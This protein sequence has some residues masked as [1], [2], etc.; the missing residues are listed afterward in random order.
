VRYLLIGLLFVVPLGCVRTLQADRGG[1]A[2]GDA[3]L[4][5][6]DALFESRVSTD[7]AST[8]GEVG[9]SGEDGTSTTVQL[10]P[11][12]GKSGLVRVLGGGTRAQ[13]KRVAVDSKGR[14]VAVGHGGNV[15]VDYIVVRLSPDGSFDTS[16]NNGNP[17]LGSGSGTSFN[18][19]A[20]GLTTS[21]QIYVAG[22]IDGRYAL[23]RL[24]VDGSLDTTFAQNG[25][26]TFDRGRDTQSLRDLAVGSDGSLTLLGNSESP[27]G[28][29]SDSAYFRV[30]EQ[31]VLTL[32]GVSNPGP[33]FD[34]TSIASLY[35]A[36]A[37]DYIVSRG[38]DSQL[39]YNVVFMARLKN[40]ALDTSFGSGGTVRQAVVSE[41]HNVWR[42]A[43]D[44][45]GRIVICYAQGDGNTTQT[46]IV[47]FAND[48][49]LDS[50]FGSGGTTLVTVGTSSRPRAVVIDNQGRAIISG[51]S[52]SPQRTFVARLTAGGVLD[53]SFAPEGV[54]SW[55]FGADEYAGQSLIDSAGRLVL[56]GWNG[57]DGGGGGWVAR[58]LLPP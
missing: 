5:P 51:T 19:F 29:P 8:D 57:T 54:A 35:R 23:I 44:G 14:L 18:V 36:A 37:G 46:G 24:K 38:F 32:G 55:D 50:S 43:I 41:L 20:M 56:V 1:D 33:V 53:R 47:R 34:S 49:T 40:S 30:S 31:G 22:G 42:A 4:A 15:G 6:K 12:F 52:V 7:D 39:G 26:L 13:L 48:G 25:M 58:F 9:D 45:Q 11:S 16:F 10:D 2:G 27:T 3:G 21:D 28:G 17:L